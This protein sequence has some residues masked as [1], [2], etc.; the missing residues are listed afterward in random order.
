MRNHGVQ[1]IDEID[2]FDPASLFID[3]AT[4]IR[5]SDKFRE[6]CGYKAYDL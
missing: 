4:D 1:S 2:W 3:Q 6:D 5:K